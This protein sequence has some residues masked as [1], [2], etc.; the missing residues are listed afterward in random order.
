M[1][2]KTVIASYAA[3]LTE[4]ENG[5]QWITV[6]KQ[7]PSGDFSAHRVTATS[8]GISETSQKLSSVLQSIC[9]GHLRYRC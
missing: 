4:E 7:E 3:V 5:S 1:N 6:T 9:D 8:L 2:T